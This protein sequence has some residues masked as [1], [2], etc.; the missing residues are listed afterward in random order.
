MAKIQAQMS[1]EIALD[2]VKASESIKS[3]TNLVNTSTNAWKAQESQLK[4]TGDYL[5]ATKAKYEGLGS[6]IQAQQA[7]IEALKQKQSELK[8]DT[9]QTAEQYLK[10][11]QQIDQATTKLSSLEVQ[12]NKAKQ[13]MSYYQSGL[14]DLQKGYRQQ[15]DLSESYVKRLQAEG[16]ENEALQAKLNGS[17]TA[18]NNL[19]K[20][21]EAQVK[22]LKEVAQS[23]DGDAYAKQKQRIN[24]T[25]SAIAHAKRE[26]IELSNELRKSNPTFF[27]KLKTGI[28]ETNSK[29]DELGRNV[30]RSNSVLGT[31]R[32]KLSF[33]AIAGMASSAIQSIS[34]SVMGLSGEVLAT[35]DSLEKFEST[36]NFA[37]KSKKETEEASKYFKTY[38]DKTVYELQDVANT[39][40]QLAS[41]GIEK[42]KEITIASG[43]LNAVAGGNKETFKSLGMVLTQTAGAG[44]LT[45]E[46]WNQLADAIPGASGKLQETLSK[47]GAFVGNFRE[48]MENGEISSE[49]FL[50]AIEQLGNNKGA[51]KAAKS[52]K[53]FEGAF[54]S[55]KSTVVNGLNDMVGVVGK[56]N[57]TKSITGFGDTVKNVFDY[58]KDHKKELSSI[59][60]SVFEISKIF[61]MA[62]WDTAKGII[63]GI[64]DSINAMNG[65]SKKSKD[66]LKNIASALK[67]VSK[68]KD[69]IK[70]VGKVLVAYFAS[71]AVLNTSKSL[72]GTITG[73]I[74]DVKKA[75]SGVNGA[76]NW[77]MGVRGED[78][79]NNKLGG[80]KKIGRGTKSAFKWTASVA[81]KTAKLALTGLLNTAKFVGNGIKLAFNFAKAN[82][83]ILIAT[84]VIGVSIA[85]YELYKHNKKFKGFVDGLVKSVKDFSKGVVEK[86]KV[87]FKAVVKAGK[88]TIDFFKKDWKEILLFL[89]NPVAGGFALIYKHNKKFKDFVDGIW[90]TAQNFGKTFWK[91]LTGFFGNIGDKIDAGYDKVT[92]FIG[93]IKSK[94]TDMWSHIKNGFK[95]MWD[96]MKTLAGNGIN[97]IIKIPNA[98]ISGINNLIADF[99]GSKNAIGKIPEV[100]FAAGTG[101]FSN[102]RRAIT[103]PTLAMLNDGHD[104]PETGHQ[105]AV[106][107]PNGEMVLPQGRNSRMVLPAGAE[108]LNATELKMLMSMQAI[109]FANGTG[110]WSK[111]WDSTTS[112]AGNAWDGIKDTAKKFTEMLGFIGGAIK[113]PAGT[114]AKKFNPNANKLDGVFN[115]LG[116]ALFKTPKTQAKGW[117]SELWNMAQSATDEGGGS[118][119]AVGDDYPAKWKAMGLDAMVDPWGYY[120]RECVSFV[121]SRLHNSGVKASLFSGLGNGY[122]WVNARVPHMSKPKVGSVAVYGPGSQFPNHVAM[123]TSVKGDR[124][125]GEE[126]NQ[127]VGGSPDGRYHTYSN[128]LASQATT[129][130]DFGLSGGSGSD[131]KPLKDKNSPLQKLI[132]KQVGGMFDW[133]QKFLAPEDDGDPAGGGGA[134]GVERWRSSVI[135]AL[136]KNGFDATDSQ[137][138]AWLKVIKRESNGDP[139]A[140]NNWDSN[141]RAGHPSQ[142]LV[143]TIDTTFNAHKF[144]G[145]NNM[146]NGY[147]S[148]LAGIHYAAW[149]YG[150]GQY[151]FDRVSGPLGYAN[152]GLVSKNGIYELA[153]GNMPEYIIPTDMAKRGRAWSLLA[154]VVGKF[155][156]EAPKPQNNN[157]DSQALAKLE[158]KFDAVVGLLTQLVANG[159]Q[160]IEVNNILDGQSFANGLVPYMN[161]AQNQFEIR[162]GHLRGGLI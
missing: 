147:D 48:A 122:Q 70:T 149:R 27:D 91:G 115:P 101:M 152:G 14:A 77:V 59:G 114:L 124:Y 23:G 55:L 61:G 150:R 31:F 33:G 43:N 15:N 71:K 85:L 9:Q 156:G 67:E 102:V 134:T 58:L 29:I 94:T 96:G 159:Q 40:A 37:D 110:F 60:K 106:I 88:A 12:Q 45:T 141:A 10:F 109:P 57:I 83:M 30:N 41:N 161:K 44:K 120:I 13:S 155:A 118:M 98:G 126:Y 116:N 54:G 73:G 17:K 50:T 7:K 103:Q 113:D 81:T 79:V 130:L 47:N 112:I 99:G 139:K 26:Q 11:Q 24:E 92:D 38:A 3:M 25:A 105:E 1:T 136:K 153:E 131:D 2:L 20:Q 129:F 49:E 39:G 90:K 69:A 56:E 117:W 146:L 128:R 74:S 89:I 143:Q 19:N 97:A 100:K 135:K 62:V 46:N 18:V 123:V 16:R 162:Q 104:S 28:H 42:Y 111:L 107:M 6:S 84:A 34:S 76:L 66:P 21:Y 119:S 133:I 108:V 125:S 86:F 22:M 151:M 145:H 137:V 144:P 32:E 78:A 8:G 158:A 72:F 75:G 154:E 82:P 64:S 157:S 68:H 142:G 53:T 132:K 51:E 140:I 87:G 148:L 4:M 138:N 95:S 127:L 65:H 52:T 5:G 160:P 80:I 36:M 121:A 35:S 93:K 63:V